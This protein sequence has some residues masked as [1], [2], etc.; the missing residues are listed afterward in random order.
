MVAINSI[1]QQEVAKGKGQ[2]EFFRASPITPFKVC[3][4]KPFALVTFRH[5]NDADIRYERLICYI[6]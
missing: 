4:K 2:I 6:I 1:P 3:G 5:I